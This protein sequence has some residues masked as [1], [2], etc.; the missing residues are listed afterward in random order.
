MSLWKGCIRN[1][2]RS[3]GP[4]SKAEIQMFTWHAVHHIIPKK[5][6]VLHSGEGREK[7]LF[8]S[9]ATHDPQGSVCIRFCL[10]NIALSLQSHLEG[11]N[12][13]LAPPQQLPEEG[14]GVGRG[15][16]VRGCLQAEE[17]A[18]AVCKALGAWRQHSK[19]SAAAVPTCCLVRVLPLP[20]N[21]ALSSQTGPSGPTGPAGGMCQWLDRVAGSQAGWLLGEGDILLWGMRTKGNN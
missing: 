13:E 2:S 8:S 11:K 5:L 3:R 20:Q 7:R 21:P 1:W 15:E 14:W 4:G 17:T 19:G 18:R 9:S 10:T 6:Q 12:D 16:Q